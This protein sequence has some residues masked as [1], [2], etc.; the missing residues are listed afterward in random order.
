M[1]LEVYPV[2]VSFMVWMWRRR[3]R[4]RR[5]IKDLSVLCSPP[6]STATSMLKNNVKTGSQ[7]R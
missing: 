2:L 6:N 7:I 5:G 3:R 1:L 4:R